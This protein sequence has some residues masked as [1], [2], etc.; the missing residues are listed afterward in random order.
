[1]YF[2]FRKD[3]MLYRFKRRYALCKVRV[4][5]TIPCAEIGSESSMLKRTDTDG[6]RILTLK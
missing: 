6:V 2:Y 1:M 4:L 5:L 3:K